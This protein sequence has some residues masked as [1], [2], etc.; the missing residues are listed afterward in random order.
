MSRKEQLGAR[1]LALLAGMV[2]LAWI[3]ASC[4]GLGP[5]TRLVSKSQKIASGE[6]S[7]A[8]GQAVDYR[9]EIPEG[10]V[11]PTLLGTFTASGGTGNDVTAAVADQV[12]YA[13]WINGHQA[14]VMWQTAGQQSAGRFELKLSPGTY[15]FGISNKFSTFSDKKVAL[16][17][18]LK[19]RL[20]E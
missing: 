8:A 6:V 18:E 7:I 3:A 16:D 15:T 20:K 14:T 9:I 4:G 19:Y 12:N 10:M 1:R 11:E 5:Q 17:V 13:N 2:L